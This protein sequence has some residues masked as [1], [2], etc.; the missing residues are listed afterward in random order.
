MKLFNSITQIVLTAGTACLLLLPSPVTYADFSR[1]AS[2]APGVAPDRF[3]QRQ[4]YRD[5]M[6]HIRSH[7]FAAYEKMRDDLRSYPLFPYLEYTYF[8]YRI[9]RQRESDI[10]AF[11][12]QYEQTPLV[13]PLLSHWLLSLAKRGEWSLFL[14]YYDDINPSKE[15]KCHKGTALMK[16]GQIGEALDHATSLWLVGFSQPDECDPVFAFWRSQNGLTPELAWQRLAL[17]LDDNESK[18]SKYLLRFIDRSDKPYATNYRLVHFQPKTIK[19]IQSFKKEDPRNREIVLHGVK[20][21]ARL[22]PED[23]AATLKRYEGIH[24]FEPDKLED[25]WAYIGRRLALKSSD[26]ALMEQLPVNLHNH[27]KLVESRLRQ[28]LKHGDWSNVI[29]LINLLPQDLKESD[30]WQYW[31]ARVLAQSPDLGGGEDDRKAAAAIFTRLSSE[32]SFYGFLS[33]DILGLDYNFQ[34][35]PRDVA[36]EQIL[37]LE[38][39]PGIQRALELFSLGERSR[40]RREWYFSTA[41]FSPS[42]REV[43]ARV[44]LRWGWYKAAIQSMIDAGKWNHLDFR[45]PMAY[46]DN[47]L[48]HAR[49]ANIPVQWSLAIGRQESAF[50]PD[51]RS[52]SGALG[53]MQLMPGTAALVARQLGV[54]Y[55]NNKEL[56]NPDL[57]IR[58]GS[59]YL[60]SMLRRYGNNRI[61]ASAAYNAGPG[62]VDRWLDPSLPF[63]IWIEL[64]PFNETRSYV[65]N[66]L[67]FSNIYSRALEENQPLLYAHEREY[68]SPP[69]ITDLTPLILN[70]PADS[71]SSS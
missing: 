27:P 70:D 53:V 43:A 44:A 61:L 32:R 68:F 51:A 35:E 54:S 64:I 48:A 33:A 28:S 47:F 10:K 11:T 45:F 67:M 39:A 62:N 20:R 14:Q 56:W 49:Q 18:L 22:D 42:E 19:R 8:S 71:D 1:S 26:L 25:T 13:E 34:D 41:D 69:Q 24:Q 4:K 29:V 59:H 3:D 50:M 16:T 21:L 60:G 23:A 12:Q 58:L 7:R 52:R 40:A 36:M 2:Y 6:A 57:N 17:A 63:D 5:A 30:R 38:Q 65:Q 31:Q 37:S 55:G 9:S 66:V 15:H 46:R